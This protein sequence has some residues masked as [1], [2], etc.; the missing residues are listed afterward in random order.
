M[1]NK[2]LRVTTEENEVEKSE[3]VMLVL[4]WPL[5]GNEEK[6]SCDITPLLTS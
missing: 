4:Y 5:E 6:T 1:S 3:G 2:S